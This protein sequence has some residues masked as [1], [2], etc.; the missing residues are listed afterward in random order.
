MAPPVGFEVDDASLDEGSVA[1]AGS[2]GS[3]TLVNE[4]SDT[5]EPEIGPAITEVEKGCCC[6]RFKAKESDTFS[7]ACRSAEGKCRRKGH[8]DQG[9]KG[10]VEPPGWCLA[11]NTRTHTDG[12]EGTWMSKEEMEEAMEKG[13]TRRRELGAELSNQKEWKET[14]AQMKDEAEALGLDLRGEAEDMVVQSV[15]EDSVEYFPPPSSQ[16][17]T[18]RFPPSEEERKLPARKTA[19]PPAKVKS[20]PAPP[21]KSEAREYAAQQLRKA[22][23]QEQGRA[24]RTENEHLR[25][26]VAE[27]NAKL[28]QQK[29]KAEAKAEAEAKGG[30]AHI[31]SE[32][33]AQTRASSSATRK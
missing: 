24:D 8:K 1:T 33:L 11:A 30:V 23:Q 26:R 29:A 14:S 7:R 5:E 10:L 12:R 9:A 28:E 16:A 15:S 27:L 4:M 3:T 2:V 22:D 31:V 21:I 19:P 17:G 18:E 13:K 20:A 6:V 25:R 32:A